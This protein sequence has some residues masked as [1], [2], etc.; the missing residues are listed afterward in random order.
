MRP[1]NLLPTLQVGLEN[2]HLVRYLMRQVAQSMDQRL[3]SLRQF[4]PE[5]DAADWDLAVAGQRVQIIKNVNGHGQLRMG[6]EVVSSK[7]GSLV[8]L[9]GASPGAST[10]V[11]IMLEV[12]QRHF[13]DA[14]ATPSWGENLSQNPEQLASCRQRH[15]TILG[16]S[17]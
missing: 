15:N 14:L 8:A 16:L 1:G 5:A 11:D 17:L 6:T 13:P 4:V 12:L 2:F 9:L 10:A 7:D 3:A